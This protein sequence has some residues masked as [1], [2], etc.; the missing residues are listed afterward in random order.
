[1]SALPRIHRTLHELDAV[2]TTRELPDG[3]V[4]TLQRL[5][6]SYYK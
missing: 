5:R 2:P 1:M 4:I 3:N 6:A